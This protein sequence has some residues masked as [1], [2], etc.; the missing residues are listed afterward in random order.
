MNVLAISCHPDDM[1]IECAG[2]LLKCKARG[3]NVTVCHVANGNMGH[4]SIM[5]EELGK[6][7]I[8][9]A[10]DSAK[11]AGFKVITLNI[12][13]LRVYENSLEQMNSVVR[14]IREAQPD[15]IITHS[16][17]DY[18][19]DH[20]AVSKLV[21]DASFVASVPHYEPE[22]GPAAKTTPIY[23][24]E[25]SGSFQFDP[26]E[27]VDVTDF[28]DTKISMLMCHKSQYV[29]LME[30]DN[31][32]VEE[33]TRIKAGFRGLQCGVKYAEAFEQEFTGHKVLPMRLLP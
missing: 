5:P 13:D 6:M 18:M 29:W 2:T 19:V 8:Q 24:M 4:F 10:Q 12:G 21:F 3:D 20:R 33:E 11:I 31:L 32:N 1:E 22:L 23:Y 7:R 14:V 30:H 16:P 25:T 9:E 27:F 17:K 26:T 28:I 15:F